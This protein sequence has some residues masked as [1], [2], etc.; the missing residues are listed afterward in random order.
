LTIYNTNAVFTFTF[1]T[2][3]QPEDASPA[4]VVVQRLNNTNIVSSVHYATVDGTAVAG[5]NYSNTFGTLTFA[6]GEVFKSVAVPLIH[7]TNVTGDLTFSV[8]LSS[9]VNAQ[10]FAP[11]NSVVIIQDAEAG[12][13]FTNV[14]MRVFKNAGN[15]VVT[16]VCSNPRVE[17]GLLGTNVLAV[18]YYTLDGTAKSNIDYQISRGTLVFTNGLGTNTFNVPLFNNQSVTGD[19][20]FTVALT[21]VT[22]PGQIT[23]YATQ[24]VVIAESNVGVRFSQ[25]NYS[26]FENGVMATI[27]V[28]RT[29]YTDSVASVNYVATNGTALAGVNFYPTNGTL[30]F[31]NGVTSQSFGV[32][33]IASTAVQPNLFALL[34]LNSPTNAQIVSPGAATLTILETGGSY[35][36]PAGSQLVSE[37]GPVDGII[38]SNE[39]VQVL[40]GFRDS[41]GLNVTNLIAY[42]MATNGVTAP[43]PVSQTYGPLTA[44]GHSV[45][46][47]F[48]FTTHGTNALT[49]APTF[50]LYDNDKF[51]GMGTF[52]FT[53]G[54]WTTTFANSNSIIINDNAAASPYPS[55]ISVSGVGNT[56]LKATVTLN[57]LSH[58]SVSDID[59]LVVSPTT[60]SLIMAHVG[61]GLVVT[62]VTLTFDDAATT[63]LSQTNTILTGTN[64]PSAYGVIR[65]FP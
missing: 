20:T 15:A 64:K 54:T 35:V 19:H 49:I 40:F 31:S 63:Y 42:L 25:A 26:V 12:I 8:N 61:G 41:A 43:V 34:S 47:A 59:A 37:S 16:V 65:P 30:V 11:T 22:A 36:V 56:L 53:V 9:P 33:L 23:P 21:N 2:N 18:S 52:V 38:Q 32:Q 28:Y 60:N 48:T 6:V 50:Q 39:T 29:G 46:R 1:G 14:T 58:Q 4:N 62:H 13:S 27:N 10:L 57:N 24:A 3:S 5:I 51:I 17:A 55:I 44:Y 7:D 45:S